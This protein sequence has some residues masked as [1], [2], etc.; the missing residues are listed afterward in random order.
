M[1]T[2][3]RTVL[4]VLVHMLIIPVIKGAAFMAFAS[5]A[6]HMLVAGSL[7]GA[8]RQLLVFHNH[9]EGAIIGCF[10][11]GFFNVLRAIGNVQLDTDFGP[12][13]GG[14]GLSQD[15]ELAP[16]FRDGSGQDKIEYINPATGLPLI[17]PTP[18]GFGGVDIH[19][20]PYGGSH[21]EW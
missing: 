8:L 6:F 16:M 11:P 19:N 15:A 4:R 18:G 17:N 14:V 2:L 7:V 20:N 13:F 12:N 9:L 5:L 10:V 1:R 21:N 3:A